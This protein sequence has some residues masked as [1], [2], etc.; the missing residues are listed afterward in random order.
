MR[1]R[2]ILAAGSALWLLFGALLAGS[3]IAQVPAPPPPPPQDQPPASP[4]ASPATPSVA[5]PAIPPAGIAAPDAAPAPAP[6]VEAANPSPVIPAV[7]VSA[8]AV[9]AEEEDESLRDPFWPIGYVSSNAPPRRTTG[10]TGQGGLS[11]T[12]KVELP[13]P[14]AEEWTKARERLQQSIRGFS[15]V[16]GKKGTIKYIALIQEK[17]REEGDEVEVVFDGTRYCW[18]ITGIEKNGLKLEKGN[19]VRLP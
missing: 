18:S 17:W 16:T 6:G 10:G 14:P 19:A 5:L 7:A 3:A 12:N 15:R 1:T 13:P 8:E 4:V 9:A 11:P 2:H